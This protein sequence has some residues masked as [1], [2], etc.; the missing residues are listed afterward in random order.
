MLYKINIAIFL[1]NELGVKII[2]SRK[3]I[4]FPIVVRLMLKSFKRYSFIQSTGFKTI[5]HLKD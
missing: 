3:A 1:V 2:S 5:V 4:Y